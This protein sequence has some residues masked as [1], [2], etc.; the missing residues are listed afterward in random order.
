MCGWAEEATLPTCCPRTC[1]LPLGRGGLS[2]VAHLLRVLQGIF[3]EA[4]PGRSVLLGCADPALLQAHSRGSEADVEPM[5]SLCVSGG[6]GQGCRTQSGVQQVPQ[7]VYRDL[8]GLL[9]SAQRAE[10]GEKGGPQ[11]EFP[12][13]GTRE[14]KGTQNGTAVGRPDCP[15]CRTPCR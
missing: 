14:L 10:N 13:E 9:S 6:G 8:P 1:H 2:Q 15:G 3:G 12:S 11:V 5:A 4:V 7:H